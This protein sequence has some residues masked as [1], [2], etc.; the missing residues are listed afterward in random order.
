M[1]KRLFYDNNLYY[2]EIAKALDARAT[3]IIRPL[4]EEFAGKGYD[5]RDICYIINRTTQAIESE[6]LLREQHKRMVAKREE[7]NEKN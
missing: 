5:I 6:H 4:M 7:I 2:T 3:K 1:T